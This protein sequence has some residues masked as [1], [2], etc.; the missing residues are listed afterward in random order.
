MGRWDPDA[1]GRLERAALE[2]F[3]EQGFADTTVPQ[4]TERAGLT[5]RTF[6]RYFADK[7]EVL[8]SGEE[9]LRERFIEIIRTA[10]ADLTPV[11]LIRHGLEAA[12]ETIFQPLLEYLR[13]WRAIVGSDGAL[14]ER[15][16][17]KQEL[18]IEAVLTVLRERGTDE[19]AAEMIAK[20]SNLVLQT[21][22]GRWVAQPVAE[23]PL[24][25]FVEE[26][27]EQL[28]STVAGEPVHR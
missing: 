24:V 18:T 1:R 12:A 7:R 15:A 13:T 8:F 17:R 21:A 3:A 19:P 4:I 10:P 2:L 14:R 22:V 16:L 20:L 5:T 9:E 6:F 23:R 27:F 26:V 28:R 11:Q 25:A